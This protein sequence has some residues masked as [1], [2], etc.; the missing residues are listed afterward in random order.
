ME[1]RYT[2]KFVCLIVVSI[3]WISFASATTTYATKTEHGHGYKI[4]K[5]VLDG[6]SKIAVSVVENYSPAQ[7][8]NT[9]M[10]NMAGN[11][12]I[13]GS[14]FCP[15]EAAYARCEGNTTDGLRI[16]NGI[17]YSKR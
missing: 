3:F 12:A 5:V 16:S 14:F 7:S 17:F 4:M 13:N 11:D 10:D 8:L 2:K 15:Q 9:L 1:S 6:K